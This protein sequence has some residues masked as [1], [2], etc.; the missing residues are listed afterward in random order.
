MLTIRFKDADFVLGGDLK[1]GGAIATL[2][3]FENGRCSYAHLFKDGT[4]KRFKKVIGSVE[5][6]EVTGECEPEMGLDSII[7]VFTDSSW[8]R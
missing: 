1:T 5:D 8:S 2:D 3:D 6:I 4:I 7:G